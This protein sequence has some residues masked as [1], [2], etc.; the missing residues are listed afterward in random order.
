MGTIVP[1][2]F[3]SLKNNFKISNTVSYSNVDNESNVKYLSTCLSEFVSMQAFPRQ[4][5]KPHL[6][7]LDNS[8]F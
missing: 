3:W 5:W 1:F 7:I 2:V 8:V 6:N 4:N